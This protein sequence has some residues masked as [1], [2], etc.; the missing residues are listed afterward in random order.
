MR[1]PEQIVQME[2]HYCV[3]HLVATLANGVAVDKDLLSLSDQAMELCSPIDDWEEAALQ[4]GWK[5]MPD[6]EE[7]CYRQPNGE[8][9]Y[10]CDWQDLCQALNID[11]V[12]REV[13]EHW[14]VSDYLANRL[15]EHGEKVDRDFAGLTIWART[16]TGQGIAADFVIQQI[17]E[18]TREM[19]ELKSGIKVY[20]TDQSHPSQ[21]DRLPSDAIPGYVV[22]VVRKRKTI[23]TFWTKWQS[24][25]E[26]VAQEYIRQYETMHECG[27]K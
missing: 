22:S 24:Q 8:A 10:A 4:E 19:T 6:E 27:W 23:E 12:Q 1:T 11:P 5:H 16:T 21:R 14:I 3:S 7:D 13:F 15:E 18:E 2:V 17:A 25:A 26:A 9:F 20:I